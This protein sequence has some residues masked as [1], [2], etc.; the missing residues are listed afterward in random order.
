MPKTLSY[1][2]ANCVLPSSDSLIDTFLLNFLVFD[3]RHF[4]PCRFAFK[5]D[6]HAIL[7]DFEP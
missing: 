4:F 3:E 1:L 2:F 7:R 6:L 5:L